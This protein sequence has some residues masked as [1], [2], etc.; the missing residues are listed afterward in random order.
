VQEGE[1]E[2]LGAR[3]QGR[4]LDVLV[5]RVGPSAD[6]PGSAERG[7][8]CSRREAGVRTAASSLALD[9]EAE[10]AGEGLLE[11][12]Q[13]ICGCRRFERQEVAGDLDPGR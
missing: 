6:R 3:Q 10:V 8:A 4:K 7:R 13:V 11:S 12:E 5:R 1:R 9:L 2:R